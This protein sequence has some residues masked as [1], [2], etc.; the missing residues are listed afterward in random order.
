M[1]EWILV[2]GGTASYGASAMTLL[3]P[4]RNG[5]GR[6]SLALS[7]LILGVI[8]LFLAIALRWYRIGHGPFMTLYE[9]LLSNAF[10]V[11]LIYA[12]LIIMVPLVQV[13]AILV[14][15]LLFMLGIWA[16]TLP[17][18]PVPLPTTFDNI[19]LW[20]HV[21][22]GKLFLGLCIAAVGLSGIRLLDRARIS[23]H[24][25]RIATLGHA[26]D[27]LIWKL[28]SVAFIFHS[29]MLV[30]GAVWA[31]DAWGRYWAWDP[32]ETWTFITW[33]AIAATLHLRL[34]V[35]LADWVGWV[36]VLCIFVLAF[37]TFF[38]VPFLSMS[39]HSGVM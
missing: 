19:W 6:R 23:M 26:I 21:T 27:L 30:M 25:P 20:F 38:G 37:L 14:M 13:G 7:L 39:P 12:L 35:R 22:A 34:S 9:V 10:S 24:D 29:I 3:L 8:L 16:V 36:L 2:W 18:D 28:I 11:G 1:P 31:H 33:L 17:F 32:L 5:I 4:A 15:P